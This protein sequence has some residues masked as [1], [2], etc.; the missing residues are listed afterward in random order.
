VC[1]RSVASATVAEWRER[2]KELDGPWSVVQGPGDL[3]QDEQV[4]AKD[5]SRN[6]TIRMARTWP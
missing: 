2:L 3:H 4:L 5:T 1:W 6:W